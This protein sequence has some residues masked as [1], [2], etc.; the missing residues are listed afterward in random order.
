[1][2]NRLTTLLAV[3]FVTFVLTSPVAAHP[4]QFHTQAESDSGEG[5]SS[6][7]TKTREEEIRAKVE[8]FRAAKEERK[9]TLLQTLCT[10]MVDH[11]MKELDRLEGKVNRAKV[12]EDQKG[13]ILDTIQEKD[14]ALTTARTECTSTTDA[15]ALKT[16]IRDVQRK[17]HLF[18]SIL[19]RLHALRFLD[20]AQAFLQR[21]EN[22]T[23]V[24]QGKID[25]ASAA[26]CDVTD[27]EAALADYQAALREARDHWNKAKEIVATFRDDQDPGGKRE[28]L[29]AEMTAMRDALKKAHEA[30]KKIKDGL[31]ECREETK[32]EDE[33]EP[34]GPTTP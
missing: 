26:G 24:L 28:E 20:K 21:L 3:P 15:E 29:K 17:H 6:G 7:D 12:T 5:S 14:T 31:K 27:E 19:P 2:M 1:M 33:T 22:Q 32:P 8:E 18:A 23:T 11:R 34:S 30:F 16:R 9:L 13:E 25:D 4:S 10:K